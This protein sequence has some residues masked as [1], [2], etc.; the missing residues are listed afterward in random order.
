M[1]KLGKLKTKS[2]LK[3]RFKLTKNG[4]IKRKKNNLRHLLTTAKSSN[5]KR[6]L[7]QSTYVH[8]ADAH[9][10]RRMMPYG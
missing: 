1:A 2:G 7:G 6:H 9:R 10:M 8:D 4:K 5:R 3:K